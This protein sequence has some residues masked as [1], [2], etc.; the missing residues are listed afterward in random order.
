M[1]DE[2]QRKTDF[3][4]GL[5]DARASLHRYETHEE[6]VLPPWPKQMYVGPHPDDWDGWL[7]RRK[8]IEREEKADFNKRYGY[9][10]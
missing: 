5:A 4:R 10:P 3:E 7:E 6:I 9:A 1:S 8:Q 2:S